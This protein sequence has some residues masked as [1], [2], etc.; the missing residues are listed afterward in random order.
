MVVV[1]LIDG[2]E[3]Q[4]FEVLVRAFGFEPGHS[5]GGRQF[6]LVDITPT[7]TADGCGRQRAGPVSPL[8]Q[9]DSVKIQGPS[10]L[11]VR[12]RADVPPVRVLVASVC[13][14]LG[15]A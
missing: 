8:A 13:V 14:G 2:L 12:R 3:I 10:S 9:S 5:L 7:G 4:V 6:D 11:P 15:R 1:D